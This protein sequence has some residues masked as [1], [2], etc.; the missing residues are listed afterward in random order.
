[1]TS[2]DLV[3]DLPADLVPIL[4][5]HSSR[6]AFVLVS[7]LSTS[8]RPRP[9]DRDEVP[10]AARTLTRDLRVFARPEVTDESRRPTSSRDYSSDRQALAK[11]AGHSLADLV[12]ILVATS[13]RPDA[14]SRDDVT[15]HLTSTNTT[16]A[17]SSRPRP[18]RPRDD[19]SDLV[20][21]LVPL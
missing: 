1:M 20:P 15:H 16:P 6:S 8:S 3:R 12:P 17:T 11:S 18:G 4:V 5:G 21:S 9:R 7:D 10:L 2:S 19:V 14:P 13:S